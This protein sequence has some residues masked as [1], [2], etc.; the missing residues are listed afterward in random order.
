MQKVVN[1][2]AKA[3]LRSNTIVLDSNA[4][5]SRSHCFFNNIILKVQ[6]QRIIVKNPYLEKLKA[7]KIKLV[8]TKV[9]KPLEWKNKKQKIKQC[10]LDNIEKYKNQ[11][12]AIGN[13]IIDIS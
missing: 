4:C 3:G 2:E 7:K 9:T 12:L 8:Y 11:I 10:K 6:I 13:N 5:C 1:T